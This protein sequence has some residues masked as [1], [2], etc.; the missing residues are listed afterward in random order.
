MFNKMSFG[1]FLYLTNRRVRTLLFSFLIE[2]LICVGQTEMNCEAYH[3]DCPVTFA[4][5]SVWDNLASK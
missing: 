3:I 1:R 4:L 5:V 2:A